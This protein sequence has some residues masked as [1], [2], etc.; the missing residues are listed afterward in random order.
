MPEFR[1]V[2]ARR[3]VVPGENLLLSAVFYDCSQEKHDGELVSPHQL[4]VSVSNSIAHDSF[5]PK[6]VLI[7]VLGEK[8]E[9]FVQRNEDG[10]RNSEA[11]RC[12]FSIQNR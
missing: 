11:G 8:Y 10:T 9:D 4:T 3:S 12:R 7:D 1:K 5:A 6:S 2:H